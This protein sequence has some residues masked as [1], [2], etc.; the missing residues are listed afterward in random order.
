MKQTTDSNIVFTTFE[1]SQIYLRFIDLQ[2]RSKENEELQSEHRIRFFLTLVTAVIGLSTFIYRDGIIT[3]KYPWLAPSVLFIL[4]LYGL[5]TLSRVIWRSRTIDH[6]NRSIK[7]LH[8]SIE[9][10]DLS[11]SNTLRAGIRD[12][13]RKGW[14]FEHLN[15]SFAQFTYATEMLLIWACALLTLTNLGCPNYAA[16]G[17]SSLFAIAIGYF[18]YRWSK[19][20]RN[21]FNE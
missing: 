8:I 7:A 2:T 21:S 18:L 3:T 12:Y 17:A 16:Y 10:L 20:I 19:T 9:Q 15:G 1:K 4:F 6:L 5:L 11:I 13:P 14:I